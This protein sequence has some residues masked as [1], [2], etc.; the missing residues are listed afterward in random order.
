V[1]PTSPVRVRT[2]RTVGD[3]LNV[4]VRQHRGVV[5]SDLPSTTGNTLRELLTS[6]RGPASAVDAAVYAALTV[7]G[8]RRAAGLGNHGAAW[9]RD[10][11]SRGEL[12]ADRDGTP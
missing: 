5:E 11:S 7:A 2:P 8:R 3:L 12:S 6:I 9:E 1:L 10:Q 4:V